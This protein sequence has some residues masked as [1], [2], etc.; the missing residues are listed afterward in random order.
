MIIANIINRALSSNF[1]RER[2]FPGCSRE[3]VIELVKV[4]DKQVVVQVA[5]DVRQIHLAATLHP[6][7]L[8][9]SF[10]SNT[11]VHQGGGGVV[12]A[13]REDDFIACLQ[14]FGG[15]FLGWCCAER[16]VGVR[17][18]WRESA[19]FDSSGNPRGSNRRRFS[20]TIGGG[21]RIAV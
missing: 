9:V 5:P 21:A 1:R 18:G 20:M 13:G 10:G 4:E 15:A 19:S 6:D 16:E 17:C 3:V 11:A 7:F 12:R 8:D 2:R 14:H